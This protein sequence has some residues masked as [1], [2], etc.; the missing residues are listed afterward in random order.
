MACEACCVEGM[1]SVLREPSLAL[2]D[3]LRTSQKSDWSA[4]INLLVSMSAS[5]SSRPSPL[6]ALLQAGQGSK[7]HCRTFRTHQ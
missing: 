4:K 7:K 1:L 2:F 6:V 5:S 3:F